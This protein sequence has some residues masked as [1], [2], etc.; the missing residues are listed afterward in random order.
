MVPVRVLALNP[1]TLEETVSV[2]GV[3]PVAGETVSHGAPLT[4]AVK[5]VLGVAASV[6]LCGSGDVPPAVAEND[7]EAGVTVNVEADEFTVKVTGTERVMPLPIIVMVPVRVPA[8]SPV[9]LEE[10]VNVAGVVP[11]AGET[12]S[13][14]SPL[15]AAVKVVLGVALRVKLCESGDV[16][17]AV[18]ENEREVGLTVNVGED[19]GLT[20][21]VTGTVRVRP[22]PVTVMVP[23]KVPAA[24]PVTRADTVR[25]A[26][27]APEE[28]ETLSQL[29]PLTVAVKEALGLA[30]I[31]RLFDAGEAPPTVAVND[32]EVGLTLSVLVTAEIVRVTGTL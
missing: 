25:V 24:S 9:T 3:V 32:N 17:P 12:V 10:T 4:V 11:V 5:A 16:P 29:A 15:T 27:V 19:D 6:R 28:G 18:A 1:V 20:V 14:G 8:E 26:G 30:V 21:K 31:D 22:L 13:H 2:A 7:S 23:V